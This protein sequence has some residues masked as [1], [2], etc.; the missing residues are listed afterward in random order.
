M[1]CTKH[2]V[3]L[4]SL[5]ELTFEAARFITKALHRATRKK[6]VGGETYISMQERASGHF[7]PSA[8]HT[9]VDDKSHNECTA[10]RVII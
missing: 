8:Y 4:V 7:I 3:T 5:Q 10:Q 9:A 6:T 1:F 2:I